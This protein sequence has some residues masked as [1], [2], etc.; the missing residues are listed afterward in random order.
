MFDNLY[1]FGQLLLDIFYKAIVSSIPI[2]ICIFPL[3][4]VISFI[5]SLRKG[6][7]DEC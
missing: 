1:D 5:K 3:G 6:R 7:E 4:F 2:A